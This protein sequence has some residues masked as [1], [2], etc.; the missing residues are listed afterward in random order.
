MSSD[1]NR[2]GFRI[3]R[4]APA[5]CGMELLWRW[6]FG[7]GLLALVVVAYAH[8][9][10]VL[11]L[12]EGEPLNLQDPEAFAESATNLIVPLLPLLMKTCAQVFTVAAV[13]W[14]AI[15]ALGRGVITR[16]IVGRFAKDYGVAIA[17]DAPRW[18]NFALL[19]SARVLM[20]LILVI[21]YLGGLFLAAF[22][23]APSEHVLATAL[24]VFTSLAIAGVV[25][26][27]VN[28]MLS[29]APLF[30]AR[31][32]ISALDATVEA[33]GFRRRHSSRLTSIAFWNNSLRTAAA[34]VIT[35]AAVLT[36]ALRGLPA[37]TTSAL[38]VLETVA[39][40]VVSD[41]FLLVRL[42]AYASVA[43]GERS[44]NTELAG[45]ADRSGNATR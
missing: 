19:Q 11:L 7:L 27:Y 36:V 28:W 26:S 34:L 1:A 9:R 2:E 30:V 39:Y 35:L 17:P 3:L 18:A 31:D 37:W 15:S 10:P 14:E 21:G 5:L 32:G 4:N 22:I 8:L 38:L 33:V 45:L 13:L 20:L 24:I 43:V 23:G 16:A 44:V 12:S 41:I 42:A 6:S 29:L 40:L 25:W